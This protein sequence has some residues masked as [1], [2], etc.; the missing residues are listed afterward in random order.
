MRNVPWE[1][2]RTALRLPA[3]WPLWLALL[4]VVNVVWPL[5]LLP[6]PEAWATLGAAAAATAI[7]MAMF[8]RLGFVRLLGLGH[9]PWVPLVAWLWTRHAEFDVASG[10]RYWMLSVMVLNTASLV[11]DVVEA[12]RY[13][14]GERLPVDGIWT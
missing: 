4:L 9:L 14:Q 1:Y 8:R 7:R 11:I 12:I 2:A 3:P 6:M 13:A 5:F 10:L